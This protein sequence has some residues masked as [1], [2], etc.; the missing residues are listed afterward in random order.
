MNIA[1]YKRTY[2]G[3]EYE[4]I[5]SIRTNDISLTAPDLIINNDQSYI[6]P[7]E[8]VTYLMIANSMTS[9]V[10]NATFEIKD[11]M[12][13]ITNYLKAQNCRIQVF[14]KKD[15]LIFNLTFLVKN[16]TVLDITQNS[17]EY[18]IETELDNCIPL[19]TIC[20]YATSCSLDSDN[21]MMENPYEIIKNILAQVNYKTFPT[22]K[23]GKNG[24]NINSKYSLPYTNEVCHFITYPNMR[25]IDAIKYLISYGIGENGSCSPAYLIHNLYYNK[26]Y[27]TSIQNI[28]KQSSQEDQP[29]STRTPFTLTKPLIPSRQ[30]VARNLANNIEVGGIENA[31]LFFNYRFFEYDQEERTWENYHI[32]KMTIND[33]ITKGINHGTQN[34][35]YMKLLKEDIENTK[36]YAYS[37]HNHPVLYDVMRNLELYSS[38]LIF[39]VDGDLNL[40][41]GQVI[42]IYEEGENDNKIEQFN[43]QWMIYKI[44]H[45][46]RNKDYDCHLF[47]SRRFNDKYNK[48]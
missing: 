40:D 30:F 5:F 25:A 12:N 11:D 1:S 17:T 34:S 29:T 21:E 26:A 6:I 39:T 2:N 20:E 24:E 41:V 7:T 19:N 35:L 46:F 43:G 36:Y 18:R 3:S 42:T 45:S 28:W 33:L 47:L 23:I 10:P 32:N 16:Y 38:N 44:Q 15:P 22:E 14:I 48:V 37:P 8:N 13:A 9:F 27:L 31:Q 4:M